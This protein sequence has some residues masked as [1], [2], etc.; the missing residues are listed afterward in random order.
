MFLPCVAIFVDS[1]PSRNNGVFII[2]G[3]VF[4]GH[5]LAL[6]GHVG[7]LCT[8]AAVHRGEAAL[9]GVVGL[10]EGAAGALAAG[11][12]VVIHSFSWT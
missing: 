12:V 5:T 7:S 4:S 9:A 3:T 10:A 8:A 11:H 2:A 6:P 1:L